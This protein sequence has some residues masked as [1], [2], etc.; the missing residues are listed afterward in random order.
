[1][2]NNALYFDRRE[3]ILYTNVA[4]QSMIILSE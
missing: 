1:M 3:F 2:K 4:D